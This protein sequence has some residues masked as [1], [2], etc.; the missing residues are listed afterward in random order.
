MQTVGIIDRFVRRDIPPAQRGRAIA[1][2]VAWIAARFDA[3]AQ[4]GSFDMLHESAQIDDDRSS[5]DILGDYTE[6]VRPWC[7]GNRRD[8]GGVV[9]A[10][11]LKRQLIE[12]HGRKWCGT[13]KGG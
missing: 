2:D 8:E 6:V 5:I 7:F 9:N 12:Q 10:T 4:E 13:G 3:T 11:R 1:E